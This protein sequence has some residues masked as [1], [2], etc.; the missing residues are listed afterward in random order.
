MSIKN[1]DR[2]GMANLAHEKV[3]AFDKFH[4]PPL[5]VF[6]LA[7]VPF[8]YLIVSKLVLDDDDTTKA[9]EKNLLMAVRKTQ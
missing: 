8:L 2:H 5:L 7:G 9:H 1:E 4:I 6:A 3:K